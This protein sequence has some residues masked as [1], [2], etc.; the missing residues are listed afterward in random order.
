MHV[1]EE[2]FT[3]KCIYTY[4]ECMS[5]PRQIGQQC[6]MFNSRRAARYLTRAYER[7]LRNADLTG[8]QFSILATLAGRGAMAISPLANALGMDRTSLT[9]TLTPLQRRGFISIETDTLDSRSKRVRLTNAGR[10]IFD[11]AVPSWQISQ[12]A[13]SA[14]VTP[15]ELEQFLHV[16][17]KLIGD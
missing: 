14:K 2:W 8:G 3:F 7:E 4:I 5:T 10:D 11:R 13:L 1:A 17:N 15:T 6:L 16:L 12:E 9:R